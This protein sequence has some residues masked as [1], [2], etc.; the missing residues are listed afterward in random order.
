MHEQ[1]L[2]LRFAFCIGKIYV[3]K[4]I[5]DDSGQICETVLQRNSTTIDGVVW[6]LTRRM[7][8]VF[9]LTDAQFSAST[10]LVTPRNSTSTVQIFTQPTVK[11]EPTD[12]IVHVISNSDDD[13][14]PDA[15]IGDTS[16]I[17][18]RRR[19]SVGSTRSLSTPDL[20]HSP[21]ISS[22]RPPV[23]PD[24]QKIRSV[25]E[26]L[27]KTASRKGSRFELVSLDFGRL[28]VEQVNYFPPQ[29]DGDKIFEL[30]PLPQGCPMLYGGDMDGMDKQY[31]GHTWYKTMTTDIANNFGLKVR[32]STCTGHIKCPNNFYEFF[33]RNS[34]RVNK[35]KW[36]V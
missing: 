28:Q 35:T 7:Y 18:I 9:G 1:L 29:F 30:P 25:V 23:H 10:V 31:D 21:S 14:I 34:G 27:I 2:S 32:K 20:R 17:P 19:A 8:R 3:E 5:F 12:V 13:A 16:A 24:T 4:E 36:T 26:A 33:Y 15:P 22:S 6:N 11:I